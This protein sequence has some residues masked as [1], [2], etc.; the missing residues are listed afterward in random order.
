MKSKHSKYADLQPY[1]PALRIYRY[2]N[3]ALEGP[4]QSEMLC[5]KEA[6]FNALGLIGTVNTCNL[7]PS[8]VCR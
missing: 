7:I 6:T 4:D 3:A 1:L 8:S 5:F 2:S